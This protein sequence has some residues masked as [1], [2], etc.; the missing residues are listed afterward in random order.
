M[1]VNSTDCASNCVFA[2]EE[3]GSG[4]CRNVKARKLMGQG[5][6]PLNRQF[7]CPFFLTLDMVAASMEY[8]KPDSIEAELEAIR[9]SIA[10]LADELKDTGAEPILSR[11]YEELGKALEA[12]EE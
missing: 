7:D 3:N 9:D 12:L 1:K 11:V 5:W 10:D 6:A 4:Y 8:N 2:I